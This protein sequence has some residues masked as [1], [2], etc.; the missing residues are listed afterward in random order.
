MADRNLNVPHNTEDR[1][2]WYLHGET[3]ENKFVD[4]CQ[5]KFNLNAQINPEKQTNK[6]APDLLV[7]GAIADLKTQN[8]PFFLAGK[9]KI[10]PRYAVTFNRKDYLRYKELY[11]QIVIYFWL[12]WTQT[13]SKWGRVDYY[14]G[15]F[16]LPF[17]DIAARIEKGA[18][19][20]TYIRRQDPD[21]RNAKSSFVLDIREFNALFT[22]EDRG[23]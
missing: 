20:H 13:V 9:Y 4:I 16:Y 5:E 7:N 1:G 22:T 6:F 11:P 19:E 2:W 3:L 10:P 8:T 14:G 12:D 23:S 15:F 18:R 21:D 17:S